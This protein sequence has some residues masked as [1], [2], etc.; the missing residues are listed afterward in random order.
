[1]VSCK[2]LKNSFKS[3]GKKKVT[4]ELTRLS[5]MLGDQKKRTKIADMIEYNLKPTWKEAGHIAGMK[6]NRRTDRCSECQP[7]KGKR[8]RGRQAE[9]GKKTW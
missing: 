1:M 4:F 6:V 7:R 9:G 3:N 8:S 5:T 2:K